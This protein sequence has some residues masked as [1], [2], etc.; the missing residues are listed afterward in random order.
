MKLSSNTLLL[1]IF[2]CIAAAAAYWYFFGAATGSD[3]PLTAT[4]TVNPA[5]ARFQVLVGQLQPISFNTS[6]FTDTRFR[7]LVDLS[8]PIAP[9]PSGRIDP[10]APVPGVK[11]Q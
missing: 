11:T 9:E 3:M 1:I 7:A 8:T 2:A 10:F 5:Q 4:Q 6:I